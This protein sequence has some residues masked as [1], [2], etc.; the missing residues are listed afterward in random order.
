M[1]SKRLREHS[2]FRL[3]V[4]GER[5]YR[6]ES[7]VTRNGD[8]RRDLRFRTGSRIASQQ[9]DRRITLDSRV[10]VSLTAQET[11]EGTQAQ[12]LG[13]FA[14]RSENFV[15]PNERPQPKGA[16]SACLGPVPPVP[17]QFSGRCSRVVRQ[18]WT[19]AEGITHQVTTAPCRSCFT[20]V[21]KYL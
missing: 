8:L 2:V 13:D 19:L 21:S 12:L 5:Q 9:V 3:N 17:R 15:D 4:S 18:E 6:R 7:F 10:R 11:P 20:R 16:F 14:G 1:N